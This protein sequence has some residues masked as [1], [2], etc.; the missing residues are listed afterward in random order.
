MHRLL[1][2]CKSPPGTAQGSPRGSGL[3][4]LCTGAL[5]QA[6]GSHQPMPTAVLGW[7][8]Q[9]G[10]PVPYRCHPG[11][12]SLLSCP[13]TV[14]WQLSCLCA[15]C[16]GFQLGKDRNLEFPLGHS[17][18]LGRA[19]HSPTSPMPS[20]CQHR[21]VPA[22]P[23]AAH[24][25]AR[26]SSCTCGM[27]DWRRRWV[28]Q[29]SLV[30]STSFGGCSGTRF[31]QPGAPQA[32]AS[33]SPSGSLATVPSPPPLSSTVSSTARRKAEPVVFTFCKIFQMARSDFMIQTAFLFGE[34]NQIIWALSS[35][36]PGTRFHLAEHPLSIG[37]PHQ[38]VL[39]H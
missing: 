11:S 30:P 19:A 39:P 4:L 29:I 18:C 33:V 1:H 27:R 26:G 24:G 36:F 10:D 15:A 7:W 6:C 34:S 12:E 8:L 32:A 2:G 20:C 28:V 3:F 35:S 17:G 25:A 38:L 9:R 14:V 22:A 21:G 13:R 16:T 37:A 5:A 31:T 23:P